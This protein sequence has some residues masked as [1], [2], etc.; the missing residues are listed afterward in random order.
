MWGGLSYIMGGDILR[1]PCL[2]MPSIIIL[3]KIKDRAKIYNFYI[4]GFFPVC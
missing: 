3:L 4:V 2:S 1:Y